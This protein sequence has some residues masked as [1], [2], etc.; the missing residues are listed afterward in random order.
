[1]L[2]MW[3]QFIYITGMRV[4]NPRRIFQSLYG[5]LAVWSIGCLGGISQCLI[6]GEVCKTRVMKLMMYCA[7]DG[8]Q[9][10]QA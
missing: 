1:M 10:L 6:D 3:Y 9:I 5:L 7:S 4:Y 8:A 2:A